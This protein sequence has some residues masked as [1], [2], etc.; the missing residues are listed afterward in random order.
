MLHEVVTCC[1]LMIMMLINSDMLGVLDGCD[2]VV[3]ALDHVIDNFG[4]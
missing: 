3:G 1:L 2:D 4:S